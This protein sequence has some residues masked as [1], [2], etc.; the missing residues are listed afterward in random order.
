MVLLKKLLMKNKNVE[1]NKNKYTL[2]F[3]ENLLLS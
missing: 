1:N 3:K 2:N